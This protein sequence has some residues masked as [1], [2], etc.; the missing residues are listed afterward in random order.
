MHGAKNP[1]ALNAVILVSKKI[2]RPFSGKITVDVSVGEV[3][4]IVAGSAKEN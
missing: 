2:V 4:M 1:F 3:V